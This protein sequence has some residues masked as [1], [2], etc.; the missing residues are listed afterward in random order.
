LINSTI[1]PQ[2]YVFVKEEYEMYEFEEKGLEAELK[3][4]IELF[5]FEKEILCPYCGGDA[6]YNP[7]GEYYKCSD[8]RMSWRE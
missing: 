6:N 5:E 2:N 3:E 8:C 7:T 4:D 1:I